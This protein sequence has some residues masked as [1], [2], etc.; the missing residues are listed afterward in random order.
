M[1]EFTWSHLASL[2]LIPRDCDLHGILEALQKKKTNRPVA[3]ATNRDLWN[4]T[5]RI[6]M[7]MFQQMKNLSFYR[8]PG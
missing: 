2:P 6:D 7:I 4:K 1:K 8:F 5:I 3:I